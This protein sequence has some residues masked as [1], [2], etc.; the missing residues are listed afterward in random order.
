MRKKGMVTENI[1]FISL[2]LAFFVM[3]MIFISTSSSG[4]AIYEQKYSKEIA[5][6]IDQTKPGSIIYINMEDALAKSKIAKEGIVNINETSGK[7]FV[8][9]AQTGGYSF[10]YFNSVSVSL[11][12]FD[13][14]VILKIGEKI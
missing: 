5:L 2:N 12:Y 11:E 3:L 4:R 1:I 8:R 7:V 9:L 6:L 14:G 13:K 10:N